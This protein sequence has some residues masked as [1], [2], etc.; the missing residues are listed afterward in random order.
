MNTRRCCQEG[1]HVIN[2]I[3]KPWSLIEPNAHGPPHLL[4]Y[5]FVVIVAVALA[6]ISF[7]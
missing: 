2:N 1:S 7:N 3:L 6:F 4:E 5:D